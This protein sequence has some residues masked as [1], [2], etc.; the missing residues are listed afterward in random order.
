MVS[1]KLAFA[2]M[3][4]AGGVM[5]RVPNSSQRLDRLVRRQGFGNGGADPLNHPAAPGPGGF[6]NGGADPL[7]HPAAAGSV[8][9]SASAAGQMHWSTDVSSV[10]GEDLVKTLPSGFFLGCEVDNGDLKD[11]IVAPLAKYMPWVT[12]GNSLKM[13]MIYENENSWTELLNGVAKAN[14]GTKL[15]WKYHTLI[16]GA[17]QSQKMMQQSFSKEAM[18]K[19]ITDFVTNK[20]CSKIIKEADF[21]GIDV[22]NEVFDDSGN[23]FKKNGYFEVIGEEGYMEVLKLVKKQCPDYKII[24]NDYGMESLNAKSDFAFKTIKK[25]LA[26]GVPIDAVGLQFHI[27]LQNTYQDMLASIKRWT[28]EKIPVVLS[29]V[30]IPIQSSADLEKQAQQYG[31]LVHAALEGGAFGVSMWGLVDSHTWLTGM[32]KGADPLLFDAKG[33]PKPAAA[34][35]VDVFKKWGNKP[36][37]IEGGRTTDLS[38]SANGGSPSGSASAPGSDAD[39]DSG[40]DCD[41]DSGSD[42]GS[43]SGTGTGSGAGT[44]TGTGSSGSGDDGPIDKGPPDT[45]AAAGGA[46]GAPGTGADTSGAPGNGAPGNGAPGAPGAGGNGAPGAPGSGASGTPGNGAPGNGAPG[47]PGAAGGNGGEYWKGKHAGWQGNVGA[48]GGMPQ[49]RMDKQGYAPK[50]RRAMAYRRRR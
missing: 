25:W 36:V 46:T 5:G 29:E 15:K 38:G 6:G 22:L 27:S 30:D 8:V 9:V 41:P 47:A 23:G 44:G 21:W 7:N 13:G 31:N 26:Q 2:L 37:G 35:I 3:L 12:P 34:A 32:G 17:E 11:P 20:M 50:H 45:G 19:T 4:T 49:M 18:M 28:S 43:R 14:Q 40:A 10:T 48:P 16:W 42:S 33:K 1:S 39:S 24:V